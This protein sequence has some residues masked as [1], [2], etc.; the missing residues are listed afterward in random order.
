MD[1]FS[2]DAKRGYRA[3]VHGGQLFVLGG[4]M[5]YPLDATNQTTANQVWM[6]TNGTEWRRALQQTLSF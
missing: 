1:N 2:F 5:P 4:I 6:T 3:M